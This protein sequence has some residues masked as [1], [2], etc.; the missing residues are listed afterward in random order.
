M[1]EEIEIPIFPLN[2]VVFPGSKINLHIFEP[3]YRQMMKYCVQNNTGFGICLI[4]NG[5]EV[6]DSETTPFEI[7]TFVEFTEI[8]ELP[9]GRYDIKVEG[10]NTFKIIKLIHDDLY[11]KAKISMLKDRNLEVEFTL[12]EKRQVMKYLTD[13]INSVA[14]FR[15]EWISDRKAPLELNPLFT[16]G[17]SILEVPNI[18]KQKI[19]ENP[20]LKSQIDTF[21]SILLKETKNNQIRLDKKFL[22]DKTILN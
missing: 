5:E 18:E 13:Y 14:G 17:M 3:R 12:N 10:I 9:D 19:L 21:I 20:S 7:G 22:K 1:E 11:L 16:Y 8:Y 15:G 6:G 2:L 4:K